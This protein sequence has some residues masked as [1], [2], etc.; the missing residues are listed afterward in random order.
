MA[1]AHFATSL[2]QPCHARAPPT[3]RAQP[4]AHSGLRPQP[5]TRLAVR[6]PAGPSYSLASVLAAAERLAEGRPPV[7]PAPK[8]ALPTA[9]PRA[10]PRTPSTKRPP[11]SAHLNES[12]RPAKLRAPSQKPAGTSAI[13]AALP[14]QPVGP[15]PDSEQGPFEFEGPAA[16]AQHP[17]GSKPVMRGRLLSRVAT[18][19]RIVTCSLVLGWVQH[20]LPLRWTAGPPAPRTMANHPSALQHPDFVRQAIA[21]LLLTQAV[22]E[23]PSR[24]IVVSPLGVVPKK[25]SQKFRL[26]FDGRYV[27]EHLVI[28]TFTYETLAHLAEWARPNDHAFTVDLTSGFHHLMMEEAAWPY[29]GFSWDGKYYVF[30]SGPFG[31]A[32]MPWAFTMLM[33]AVFVH[34][35]R[36][37]HRCTGYIDDSMWFHETVSGLAALRRYALHVFDALGLCVN[38]DKSSLDIQHVHVY[39]GMEVDLSAGLFRVP[40]EKR[41]KLFALIRELLH[42]DGGRVPVRQ[43]ASAK[44]KLVSM[45]WAFGLAAQFFTKAMDR[46]IARAPAWSATIALSDMSLQELRFWLAQFDTFNGIAPIWRSRSVDLVIHVDAAGRSLEAAGGWG[47][48]CEVAGRRLVARGAWESAAASALSSSAQ[49]LKACLNGLKSFNVHCQGRAVQLVTDSLNAHLALTRGRV[50]ARDSVTVAQEI[51]LHCT[52]ADVRLSSVWVPREQNRDADALSKVVDA[53]DCMLDPAAFG[54]IH[55]MWGPFAIDLF[56]SHTTHQLPAYFSKDFTPDTCGVD[57]FAF[58]WHEYGTAWAYPPFRLI[59]S[60]WAHALQ[61]G[62]TICLLV[63]VWPTKPWWRLI[64]PDADGF[65]APPVR[66]VHVLPP[67]DGLVLAVDVCGDRVPKRKANWPMLALL[68][69]FGRT[70]SRADRVALPATV[71]Y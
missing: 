41:D 63:P 15:L 59:A 3:A 13:A 36:L 71:G 11:A 44:G 12:P 47:A 33:R 57:A 24:P 55:G 17:P 53:D 60:T 28:P 7:E 34:F 52:S 9:P 35:R 19:R 25:G 26:I 37:G 49:E 67:R 10:P 32:T 5:V 14:R 56:A 46:D 45:G 1:C 39:L 50:Y 48:W 2:A 58:D 68:V 42:A 70:W 6:T 64:A 18:W 66:A 29:L 23:W 16:P 30:T 4:A 27:N 38:F 22:R 65:F 40:A 51:F 31:L 69:D 20:G 61:C 54:A 62:A 8:P 21:D 43:L